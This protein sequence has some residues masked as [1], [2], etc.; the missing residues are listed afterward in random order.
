MRQ[1][2]ANPKT[3]VIFARPGRYSS[4]QRGRTVNPLGNLRRFESCS[5]H[6]IFKKEKPTSSLDGFFVLKMA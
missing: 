3:V 1:S 2:F 4:G 5:S 6:T